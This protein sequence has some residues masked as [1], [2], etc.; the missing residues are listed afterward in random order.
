MKNPK[1]RIYARNGDHGLDIYLDVS[2]ITHYL[3][4]RRPNGL[5]YLWL[6]GGRTIGE[7]SRV[8]P[9]GSQISQKIFHYAQRL[10]RLVE[11]YYQCDLAA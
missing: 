6:R 7:L 1:A 11:D 3:T 5:L 2:G 9:K 4:T 8:K 10:L